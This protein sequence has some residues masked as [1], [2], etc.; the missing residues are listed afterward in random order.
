MERNTMDEEY[1][2]IA[3]TYGNKKLRLSIEI[4]EES[5]YSSESD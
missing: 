2:I 5:V 4:K 1:Q 3:F